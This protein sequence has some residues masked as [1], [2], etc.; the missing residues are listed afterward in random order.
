MGIVVAFADIGVH[1]GK[2]P[3]LLHEA[4]LPL[5]VFGGD[6]VETDFLVHIMVH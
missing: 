6:G 4:Q 2:L 5:E 3:V 1:I